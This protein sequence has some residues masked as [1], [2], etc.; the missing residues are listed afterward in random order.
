[1]LPVTD[2]AD[3]EAFSVAQ[4][5]TVQGSSPQDLFDQRGAG[6]HYR[7][8]TCVYIHSVRM[9]QEQNTAETYVGVAGDQRQ[10]LCRYEICDLVCLEVVVFTSWRRQVHGVAQRRHCVLQGENADGRVLQFCYQNWA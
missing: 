1:M 2:R 8:P 4:L 10:F 6:L 7:N 3:N 5:I 9:P